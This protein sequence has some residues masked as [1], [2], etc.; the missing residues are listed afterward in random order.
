VALAAATFRLVKGWIRKGVVVG[1]TAEVY[2]FTFCI[3]YLQKIFYS[4]LK[5]VAKSG[6]YT[7][8]TTESLLSY[9]SHPILVILSL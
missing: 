3:K 4:I 1:E 2:V 5:N 6:R 8:S 7:V 9:R